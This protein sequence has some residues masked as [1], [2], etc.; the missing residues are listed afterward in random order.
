M[1]P[2]IDFK[3][4]I[5]SALAF[6]AALSWN[7]AVETS[8]RRLY[9]AGSTKSAHVAVVYAIVVTV[10]IILVVVAINHLSRIAERLHRQYHGPPES[11]K[12]CIPAQVHRPSL[13][14]RP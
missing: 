5:T 13:S 2:P 9:P 3:L 7:N 8:I 14:H 12:D 4:L 6:A 10:L 11:E 1:A